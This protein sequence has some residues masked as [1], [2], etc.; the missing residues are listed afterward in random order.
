M[1]TA[2]LLFSVFSAVI[3]YYPLVLFL[4]VASAELG[5]AHTPMMSAHRH[6]LIESAVL[7]LTLTA[8]GLVGVPRAT[9]TER[10]RRS[11]IQEIDSMTGEEFEHRLAVLFRALGY[12][13]STTRATGDFG[14]D[15]VLER[16]GVRTVV[17]AKR[18]DSCV[19]IEA[20]YEVV[21]AKAHY[22]ASEAV[23]VT[24][25]LFT[26]AAVEMANDNDVALIERDE[27]VEILASQAA[28][29]P[30]H[31][32]LLLAVRQIASGVRFLLGV[33]WTACIAVIGLMVA[34]RAYRRIV[35]RHA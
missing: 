33:V 1:R 20:V 26:P 16:D 4:L 8:L 3:W 35:S 31:T 6:V 34:H 10:R 18:W 14:A 27:L 19:G 21:G 30:P 15:L 24:N 2:R 5:A 32:G 25:L 9:R 23:V 11:G 28:V 17:Q 7:L 22:G 13:V 12:R 29:S